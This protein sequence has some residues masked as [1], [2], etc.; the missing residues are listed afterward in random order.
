MKYKKN[1]YKDQWF[2]N[3]YAELM[4]ASQ[5][6]ENSYFEVK[7]I[8][9][10]LNIKKGSY[11][12]DSCCGPGRSS[13][14]FARAG[15]KVYGVDLNPQYLDAAKQTAIDFELDMDFELKDVLEFS[16]ENTFDLAVNLYTSF[17][18]FEDDKDDLVYLK[19]LHKSL[20]PGGKLLIDTIGKELL[21][22][23]FKEDEWF[24]EDGKIICLEYEVIDDF[25]RLV[26]R[27]IIIDEEGKKIDYK[28]S[29]RIFSAYEVKELLTQAGFAKVDVYGNLDGDKYDHKAS[30]QIIVGEK[31]RD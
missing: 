23:D 4:F 15:M 31:A 6:W 7:K 30:R 14:E 3:N 19:N 12:L 29:H 8:V 25:R 9:K 22:K 21:M 20:K 26:N 28:F 27:W 24:E 11:V 18:Y 2:W 16:K 13:V 1:W 5:N 10:L 17:G